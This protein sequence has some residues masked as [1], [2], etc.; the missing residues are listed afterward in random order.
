MNTNAAEI[1]K[2]LRENIAIIEYTHYRTGEQLAARGTL[3]PDLARLNIANHSTWSD[4]LAFWEL[5]KNVWA[6]V[7]VNTIT[8]I[9]LV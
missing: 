4:I 2:L 3:R 6:S 5:D 7:Y 1:A 8:K 9:T